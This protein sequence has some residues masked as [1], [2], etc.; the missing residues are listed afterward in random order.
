MTGP[1]VVWTVRN[2]AVSQGAPVASVASVDVAVTAA[3]AAPM[4]IIADA[5]LSSMA[6]A[7]QSNLDSCCLIDNAC[8][9]CAKPQ[10]E[11]R[12][13]CGSE[14]SLLLI[15]FRALLHGGIS[16]EIQQKGSRS[17]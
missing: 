10:E 9:D 2:R 1:L 14:S 8:L 13:M 7:V 17:T 5:V 15:F 3:M 16:E 4:A 12:F 11:N 6:S